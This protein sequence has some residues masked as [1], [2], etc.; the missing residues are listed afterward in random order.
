MGAIIGFLLL[1]IPCAIAL[2]Y[3]LTPGGKKWLKNGILQTA[4][5]AILF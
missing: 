5:R 3:F 4:I 2:V 1:G